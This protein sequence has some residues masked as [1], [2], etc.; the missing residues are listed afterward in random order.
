[1]LYLFLCKFILTQ[2]GGS[3]KEDMYTLNVRE[4]TNRITN[5][6]IYPLSMALNMPNSSENWVQRMKTVTDKE[7]KT[8]NIHLNELYIHFLVNK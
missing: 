7:H 3:S 8:V 4:R 1:M 5:T 2:R 6:E